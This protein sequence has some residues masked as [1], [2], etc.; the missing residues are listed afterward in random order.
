MSVV[1]GGSG[2]G[3]PVVAFRGEVDVATIGPLRAEVDE[4]VARGAAGIVFDLAAATF[5]DSSALAL[6]AQTRRRGV[7]VTIRHPSDLV[8]RVIELTGLS[9]VVTVEA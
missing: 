2:G 9:T 5:L 1:P 8:R 6:F 7:E 4:L 3:S